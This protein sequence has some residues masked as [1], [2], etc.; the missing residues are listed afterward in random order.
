MK[1]P[2]G[3]RVETVRGDSDLEL[4]AAATESFLIGGIYIH[5]P[6]SDYVTIQTES[7]TVAYF[8]V[9]GTQ[10]N[11]LAFPPSGDG[12]G[13]LLDML[14]ASGLHRGFPVAEGQ[15]FLISGAAQA[16]AV[17]SV[18]YRRAKSGQY[19]SE[20]PNGAQAM[21]RDQVIYGRVSGGAGSGANVYGTSQVPAEWHDFPFGQNA[22]ERRKIQLLALCLSDVG[23]TSS[24]QSNRQETTF[25]RYIEELSRLW[26]DGDDNIVVEGESS[27]SADQTDVAAGQNVLGNLTEKDRNMPLVLSKPRTYRGGE[28]VNVYISTELEAGSAN[29][30]EGDAEIAAVQR[31]TRQGSRSR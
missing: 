10:G 21:D 8:R 27:D 2:E 28:E 13:N 25:L 18:L 16:G 30:A 1:V 12:E 5:N 3:W 14:Y 7:T 31:I 19:K 24:T 9:G 11:H 20:Q 29:F 4:S 23:K 17:Q 22:P 6:S 26:D 15:T